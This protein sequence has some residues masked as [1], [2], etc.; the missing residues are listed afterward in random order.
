MLSN[1]NVMGIYF[2]PFAIDLIFIA[3]V[4]WGVRR[5]LAR[6]N[7]FQFVWHANLFE[8]SLFVSM[9]CG[10]MLFRYT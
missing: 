1:V 3:L 9:L 6:F 7:V 8:F 10:Y 4:Y 2:A 5:I